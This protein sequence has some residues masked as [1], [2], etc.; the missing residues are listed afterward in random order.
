MGNLLRS[1]NRESALPDEDGTYVV[2]EKLLNSSAYKSKLTD[3]EILL[4]MAEILSNEKMLKESYLSTEWVKTKEI[5]TRSQESFAQERMK[6]K[7]QME[8][9]QEE[10]LDENEKRSIETYLDMI[11]NF[12]LPKDVSIKLII[13]EAIPSQS[14]QTLRGLMSPVLS[15]LNI[16]PEFGLYHIGIGVAAWILEWNSSSL[17]IPRK[18]VS[19]AALM[20]IDIDRWTTTELETAVDTMANVIV[21]W[22]TT[23]KYSNGVG[24]RKLRNEGNCQDF[25]DDMLKALNIE[26]KF[27]GALKEFLNE[28]RVRG[29]SELRFKISEEFRKDFDLDTEEKEIV[30][31]THHQLDEFC[32]KLK[33]HKHGYKLTSAMEYNN[34]DF[35]L[36]SFDRAFWMKHFKYKDDSRW[37]PHSDS[38]P[39]KDPTFTNSFSGFGL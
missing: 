8:L 27:E 20:S 25:V 28:L 34:E 14:Q 29:K 37:K 31:K 36:K 26:I 11:K 30:F 13:S 4:S 32:K 21:K 3:P 15:T 22:N 16:Q 9:L 2:R 18:M 7:E 17:C 33:S 19:N 5:W 12:D 10:E 39:Y 24:I 35:L 38:C 1:K 23:M 6:M